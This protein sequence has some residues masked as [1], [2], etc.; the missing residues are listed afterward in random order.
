[1]GKTIELYGFPAGVSI[2]T[3]KPFVERYTGKDTVD[4]IRIRQGKGRVPRA[5]AI[6][7]FK[8]TKNASHIISLA[9]NTLWY[10]K[11]YLKARELEKDV[12]PKPRTFLHSLTDVK[13]HFGCQISKDRFYILW[14]T[15]AEEV[16]FGIGMRK[17][18]FLLSHEEVQYKL[19][20]SYENIWQIELHRP[21]GEMVQYLLIQ[22]VKYSI[23]VGFQILKAYTSFSYTFHGRCN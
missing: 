11:S 6:I 14:N 15:V 9:K 23:F 2:Y 18:H 1:M 13:L 3:V 5:I 16:N 4:A 20:L 17:L 8:H 10:G 12:V 22:V 21:H 7:Q 19:E